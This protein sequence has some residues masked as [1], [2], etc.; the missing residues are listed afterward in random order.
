M[1][2]FDSGEEQLLNSIL[3][4]LENGNQKLTFQEISRQ[5]GGEYRDII[6]DSECREVFCKNKKI[7]LTYTEFEILQLLYQNPGRGFSKERIF[8]VVWKEPYAGDYSIVMN[9]ISHIREKIENNPRKPVYIQTVR[10]VGY[11]FNDVVGSD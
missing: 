9:H 6:V 1:V 3:S 5:S 7:Q 10:N 4:V 11:K 2:S 8:D